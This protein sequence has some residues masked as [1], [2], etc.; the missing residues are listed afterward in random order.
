MSFK[1]LPITLKVV[2]LL[3]LLGCLSGFAALYAAG[4]MYTIDDAYSRL[5]D[6][7]ALASMDLPR[8]NRNM[9]EII[10]GILQ[11]TISTDE[12]G[13]KAALD[14]QKNA[15]ELTKQYLGKVGDL[16]PAHKSE[17]DDLL[18][19]LTTTYDQTCAETLRLAN[20]ESD[21]DGNAKAQAQMEKICAPA[22]RTISKKMTALNEQLI[23]ETKD[24]SDK[25]S[26]TT[27]S[28]VMINYVLVFGGLAVVMVIAVLAA[29]FGISGPIKKL[30]D[31]M[32]SMAAG[33]LNITVTGT[34]RKDEIGSMSR[35]VEEFRKALMET[36]RMRE[37]AAQ[38][39]AQN[40]EKMKRAR[41]Q[42]ADQFQA[43]MGSLANAFAKSSS[44][45]SDAAKNLS[46]TA[47]ETSRQAQARVRCGRRSLGQCADGGSLNGRNVGLDPRDRGAGRQIERGR[48]YGRRRGLTD[49]G[50]RE[51]P[52]GSRD[53]DRRG[54]RSHQ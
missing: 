51:S 14:I 35:T 21:K 38:T 43:K 49:R 25:L 26:S 18:R 13:D 16:V 10:I 37:L 32:V 8:A 3:F 20:D 34:E 2:S 36:E 6:H 19:E 11:N 53:Q 48:Q 24:A 54:R 31:I 29:I 41:N 50:R 45:V 17:V 22:F 33:K 23:R 30:N 12:A 15:I 40:A 27:N 28:T 44:E 1:N 42:I 4:K 52:F 47:E 5:I 39:E 46:A 7:S 9:S